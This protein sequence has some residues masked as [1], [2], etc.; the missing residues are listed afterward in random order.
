MN[1]SLNSQFDLWKASSTLEEIGSHHLRHELL[2]DFKQE[3]PSYKNSHFNVV[4]IYASA[5]GFQLFFLTILE[6]L[7]EFLRFDS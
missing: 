4:I 1:V 3:Q 6:R 7:V 2:N 5:L